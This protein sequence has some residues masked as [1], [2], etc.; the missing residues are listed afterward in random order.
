MID[1]DIEYYE[2]RARQET[3]AAASCVSLEAASSH[4]LL[5]I[6]YEGE[7]RDLRKKVLRQPIV[8]V[9]AS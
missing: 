3:K 2:M 1:D 4:R 5:A 8:M 7:V 9:Q 6:Q